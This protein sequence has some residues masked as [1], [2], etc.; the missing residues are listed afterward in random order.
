[1][2]HISIRPVRSDRIHV[3]LGCQIMA[4]GRVPGKRQIRFA[5]ER[6]RGIGPDT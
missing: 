2:D 6:L 4:L 5:I 1:M 3:V